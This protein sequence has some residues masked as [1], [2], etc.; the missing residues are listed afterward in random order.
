MSDVTVEKRFGAEWVD[1][2][3]S[4]S[5]QDR[6]HQR[7]G[8]RCLPYNDAPPIPRCANLIFTKFSV[9]K[10]GGQRPIACRSAA[11]PSPVAAETV[12]I[13]PMPFQ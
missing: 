3:N 7:S 9:R 11:Q 5:R 13:L 8:Q 1:G 2:N 4:A 10:T 6:R 12:H